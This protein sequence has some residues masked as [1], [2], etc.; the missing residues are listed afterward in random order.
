MEEKQ[1]IVVVDCYSINLEDMVNNKLGGWQNIIDL[2]ISRDARCS[3]VCLI[4]A[5]KT[6]QNKNVSRVNTH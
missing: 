5:K 4:I 3:E 2:K 6:Q 1:E